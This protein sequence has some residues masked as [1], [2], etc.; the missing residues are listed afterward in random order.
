MQNKQSNFSIVDTPYGKTLIAT[1][2]GAVLAFL[3]L[4]GNEEKLLK[5][6]K[7]MLPQSQNVVLDT[8]SIIEKIFM[9]KKIDFEM[10]GTI[11][12]KTVWAELLKLNG[13]VSY[14]ELANRIGKPKAVRAVANAVAK[15]PLHYIIPC[16][17][18][19]RSDG[20]TGKYAGGSELKQRLIQD[21]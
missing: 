1:R 2:G 3:F 5:Q 13:V 6:F 8:S 4:C 7:K 12:Q 15:N 20:D 17:L 10:T 14:Q 18:V 19:I 21:W 16:H 11:F 9:K